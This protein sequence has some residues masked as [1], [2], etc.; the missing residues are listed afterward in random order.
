MINQ[1]CI[2]KRKIELYLLSRQEGR[3]VSFSL[4]VRVPKRDIRS[5]GDDDTIDDAGTSDQS[6]GEHSQ[7]CKALDRQY[8]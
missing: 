1:S 8:M 6:A 4:E 3:P 7:R 5:S 2:H